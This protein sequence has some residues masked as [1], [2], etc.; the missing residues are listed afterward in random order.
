VVVNY[1]V[2][3]NDGVF[4]WVFPCHKMFMKLVFAL[5]I[6]LFYGRHGVG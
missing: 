5:R 2:V 4:E 3:V 1:R 6:L